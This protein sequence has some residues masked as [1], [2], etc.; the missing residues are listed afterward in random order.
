MKTAIAAVA[1]GLLI[2]CSGGSSGGGGDLGSDTSS[3]SPTPSAGGSICDQARA[4]VRDCPGDAVT[5][6]AACDDGDACRA[7]CQLQHPCDAY[8]TSG[9]VA[10]CAQGTSSSSS[11][12]SGGTPPPPETSSSSSSS[13]GGVAKH[14]ECAVYAQ[15]YCGCLG[16]IAAANCV[17]GQT[18]QCNSYYDLCQYKAYTSCVVQQACAKGWVDI[19][20]KAHC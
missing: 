6:S 17:Q 9:C 14:P 7:A 10:G 2:A 18:D 3:T 8:R 19:C 20:S 12:S 15:T 4:A 16:S 13:S 1:L 5:L 11:S